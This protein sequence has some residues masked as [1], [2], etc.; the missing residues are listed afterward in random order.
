MI[1]YHGDRL[2]VKLKL[3]VASILWGILVAVVSIQITQSFDEGPIR[4]ILRVMIWLLG[5]TALDITARKVD[6]EEENETE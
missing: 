2:W 3:G 5:F 4:S 6:P 1:K